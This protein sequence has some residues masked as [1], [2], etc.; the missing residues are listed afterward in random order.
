LL[1]LF[2]DFVLDTGQREL[3]RGPTVVPIAPQAFDF[4]EFL[5]RNR[6]R[7]LTKDDLIASIWNGR[8][9][10]ESALS[11]CV[12]AARS[13]ID[14]RGDG[15]RLI[16]TVPRKGMRFVGEVR[17]QPKPERAIAGGAPAEESSPGLTLPDRPSIAVLPFTNM[18]DDPQQEYFADGMVEEIITALRRSSP[19]WW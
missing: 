13:A 18:S 17:E 7:V 14:D 15:Q 16:R 8:I 4:L 5:I 19:R 9:V 3:R 12:N 10:S 11:S 2:E 1:Y 6:E